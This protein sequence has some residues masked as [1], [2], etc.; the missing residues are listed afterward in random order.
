MAGRISEYLV[1][2]TIN[3][4]DLMDISHLDAEAPTGY[5]TRQITVDQLKAYYGDNVY[6]GDD[7]LVSNR[8]ID[9]D[10]FFWV[11]NNGTY[12]QIDG[13]NDGLYY[14]FAKQVGGIGTEFPVATWH[15]KKKPEEK[16]IYFENDTGEWFGEMDSTGI[17]KL[18]PLSDGSTIVLSSPGASGTSN[19]VESTADD[20]ILKG[21][22]K[23]TVQGNGGGV[24]IEDAVEGSNII[25]LDEI[26]MSSPVSTTI[27][28]GSTFV[29]NTPSPIT[30]DTTA[31]TGATAAGAQINLDAG[32][33]N[34]V[35][36]DCHTAQVNG[37]L[38][39][40]TTTGTFRPP[41]M[42]AAQASAIT[43]V[44]GDVVYVTDTDDTFTAKGFWGYEE[45][46]WTK[47][48]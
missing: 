39:V 2:G 5:V 7:A 40:S 19:I 9:Q 34:N 23:V 35:V 20:F 17:V 46:A 16:V 12:W 26:T 41:I 27:T 6:E 22:S 32:T 45:G 29:V 8:T 31:G 18:Q 42:T 15:I 48:I 1:A 47:I 33:D 3:G 30:L 38:H 21:A 24:R 13:T 14:D 37:N 11:Q 36:F 4:S 10:G 28:T 44:N 25:L 43:A